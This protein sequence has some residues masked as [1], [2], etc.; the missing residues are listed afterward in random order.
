MKYAEFSRTPFFY[1]TPPAAA[2][3]NALGEEIIATGCRSLCCFLL[4]SEEKPVFSIFKD[5]YEL[6]Y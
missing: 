1:R 5:V 6:R 2:S 3:D 4:T